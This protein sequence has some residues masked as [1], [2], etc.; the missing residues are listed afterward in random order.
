MADELG[1]SPI[2][3]EIT[4]LE[5][6]VKA[7]RL[8]NKELLKTVVDHTFN[9]HSPEC[10]CNKV[11]PFCTCYA[12]LPLNLCIIFESFFKHIWK[13]VFK[14]KVKLTVTMACCFWG[15]CPMFCMDT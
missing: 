7:L 5:E 11:T 1:E 4:G 14:F 2:Q 8:E 15:H 10:V 6:E 9:D 3:D 12:H 13:V